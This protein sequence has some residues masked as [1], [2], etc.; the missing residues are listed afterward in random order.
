MV[1]RP[2][3]E[4]KNVG[5]TC[6]SDRS[7]PKVPLPGMS[8]SESLADGNKNLP[9]RLTFRMLIATGLISVG[10][11]RRS[12]SV[13]TFSKNLFSS[14]EICSA[15]NNRMEASRV[16]ANF[17]L[18]RAPDCIHLFATSAIDSRVRVSLR[19]SGTPVVAM[20]LL[21]Y[22]ERKSDRCTEAKKKVLSW[23]TGPPNVTPDSFRRNCGRLVPARLRK[24]SF[25]LNFSFCRK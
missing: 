2:D 22:P 21:A 10:V 7:A 16:A 25:A 13:F 24:N 8:G 14:D 9:L 12:W 17:E 20:A 15:G 18:S 19:P 6:V 23:N 4:L 5:K 11:R 1:P 3:Q